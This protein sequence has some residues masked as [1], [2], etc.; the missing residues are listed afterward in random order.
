MSL[1]AAIAFAALCGFISLSYEILWFRVYSYITGTSPI[2][3]GLLLGIYLA[4]L[5]IGADIAGKISRSGSDEGIPRRRT[6]L[7]TLAFVANVMG[8]LVVPIMAK[9]TI[10]ST[11]GWM[12]LI[13][14]GVA[15]ALFGALLPLVSHLGI[16]AD[17]RTGEKLSYVYFAN[18]VGSCAGS[19]LTG[20]VLMDVWNTEKTA[21]F[22]A[23]V[24]LATIVPVI[25][26]G[27]SRMRWVIAGIVSA[28][29]AAVF[30]AATPAL[31]DR[32]Y[33]KLQYKDT[34]HGQRFAHLVEN[35]HG[36]VSVTDS[37][38]TY[39]GGA[40]DGQ[41]SVGLTHDVNGIERAY[42]VS[43]LHPNPR[44]VLMIGLSTGAWAQVIANSPYVDS[45]A[46]VEI[47]PG[48]LPIIAEY[49]EVESILRNPKI[50][51]I[52]DDGRRWMVHNPDRKFDFIVSNTM[53]HFRAN[54]TNLL[55]REFLQLIKSHL[56][57]GGVFLYNTT[58]SQDAIK[59]ALTEFKH[60]MRVENFMAVSDRPMAFDSVRWNSVLAEYRI[61]GKPVFDRNVPSERTRFD[62]LMAFATSAS[63][64]PRN[65]G[66]KGGESLLARMPHARV[67][68]DDNML[69]EWHT[70]LLSNHKDSL[71]R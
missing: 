64:P 26:S 70:L 35:R 24:G 31:F 22:L 12:A 57:D 61:D 34:Y 59:T 46:V 56:N 4:G 1:A 7:A 62:T 66:L 49:A 68:T 71:I 27:G 15:S 44:N 54:S 32:L 33:E 16:A 21:L 25:Y 39:G 47:N 9:A 10:T 5:A 41:V 52:I 58:W 43:A 45:L 40:Y 28:G 8:F 18:I 30:V 3:F 42:A 63:R 60:G 55:S 6:L 11:G 67:V 37:G 29:A 20:F 50:R 48:Y 13:P 36:V 17:S 2:T 38:V 65:F 69:P 51:I 19:L 14:V 23:L 53:I